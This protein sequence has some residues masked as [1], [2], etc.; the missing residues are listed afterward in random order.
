MR[1]HG[2]LALSAVVLVGTTACSGSSAGATRTASPVSDGALTGTLTVFAAASLTDVFRELG[3]E[4]KADDP[5]LDIRF[6]FAGSSALA[7]QIAQGAPADVFASAN[8]DQMKVV[9]DA[10]L[11]GEDPTIFTENVLEIAVPKRNPARITGLADFARP[12]PVLAL[13]APD[14]PCGAAATKVFQ[15]AGITARPDTLEEDVRAALTKVQLGEVDAA[16]VYATDVLAAGDRVEGFEFPQAEQAINTYPIC[17]LKAAPN[18]D[19]AQAFVDLVDSDEG[20]AALA[21]AGFRAP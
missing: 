8:E 11:Q 16:L 2:L 18:P 12:H 13:C 19:A 9:T 17:T 6:N 1:A 7:T 3:D 10:G 5:D 20:K 15:A 4:L 14:V 21:H